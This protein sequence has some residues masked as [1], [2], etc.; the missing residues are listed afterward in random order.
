MNWMVMSTL[1]V[2]M[3]GMRAAG[4]WRHESI[5]VVVV[6]QRP[7]PGCGAMAMSM[8]MSWPFSSSKCQGALV[9]PVPTIRR[10]RSST[11]RSMLFGA[12]CARGLAGVERRRR[13]RRPPAPSFSRCGV[14]S[15]V[16]SCVPSCQL[17]QSGQRSSRSNGAGG[18]V[19]QRPAGR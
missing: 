15:V 14:R 19:R 12:D 1:P 2:V 4:S 10:P 17:P 11:V 18:D 5:L 7:W 13:A 3:F 8:P 6:E 16:R 9:L